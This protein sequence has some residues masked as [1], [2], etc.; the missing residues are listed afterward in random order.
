MRS[1]QVKIERPGRAFLWEAGPWVASKGAEG[2]KFLAAGTVGAKAGWCEP[3]VMD[4][5]GGLHAQRR[6]EVCAVSSWRLGTVDPSACTQKGALGSH[7]RLPLGVPDCCVSAGS[8]AWEP[9]GL[10]M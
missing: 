4:S 6:R 10:W 5:E 1:L 7:L 3:G 2:R 9:L 8:G